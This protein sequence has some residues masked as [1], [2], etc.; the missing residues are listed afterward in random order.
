MNKID[1]QF[2]ELVSEISR[3]TKS[4]VFQKIK[5]NYQRQQPEIK[6][7]L[8]SYYQTFPYWGKLKEQSQKNYYMEY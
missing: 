3:K 4:E 5:E 1:L 2:Q 7:A 8:E 6:I